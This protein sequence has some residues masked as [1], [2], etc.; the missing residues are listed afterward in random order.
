M[1]CFQFSCFQRNTEPKDKRVLPV[2]PSPVTDHQTIKTALKNFQDIL[3]HL[4]QTHFAVTCDEGVYHIAREITMGNATEFENIAL[5]LGSF[6]MA[7]IFLGC[8]RKYLQNNYAESIRIENSVFGPNEVPSVLGGTHYVRSF[9]GIILLCET[10]KRLQWSAFFKTQE[11]ETYKEELLTLKRLQNSIAE[12][13]ADRSRELLEEFYNSSAS[14]IESFQKFK[15][16]S[17][18]LSETFQYWD[19]FIALVAI[20]R[21]LVRQVV[22]DT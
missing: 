6:H 7:N 3:K 16:E 18:N 9:K 13:D 10:M 20:L 14:I 4:S 11:P 17:C 1:E 12:K 22:K 19:R 5:C 8:L 2:I 15:N 21:N